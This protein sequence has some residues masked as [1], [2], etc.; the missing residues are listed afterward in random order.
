MAL[1][2]TR[3]SWKMYLMNCRLD[4]LICSSWSYVSSA[5]MMLPTDLC[6]SAISCRLRAVRN[7]TPMLR[8]FFR[9]RPPGPERVRGP[10]LPPAAAE[11][12]TP[13][14][15]TSSG[16]SGPP[17]LRVAERRREEEAEEAEEQ[18]HPQ[19]RRRRRCSQDEG[20]ARTATARPLRYP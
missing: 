19:Q 4:A 1:N 8:F 15:C 20:S 6:M 2:G 12:P 3:T 9:R 10:P 18:Q 5:A 13:T 16:L 14:S 7:S 17:L 11:L